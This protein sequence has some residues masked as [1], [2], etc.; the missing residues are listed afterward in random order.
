MKTKLLTMTLF[1]AALTG[2]GIMK[3]T[4]YQPMAYAG[5]Y[6][7]THIHDNVYYVT[8]KA[9]GYTDTGTTVLYFHRR[10]K[11]LCIEKGFANY[12]VL[13]EKDSSN[14]EAFYASTVEKPTYGGQIECVN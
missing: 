14:F 9:N 11:E 2:C 4:P 3:P 8:F 13:S 7:D 12:R 1:A 10:A 6:R 5:G